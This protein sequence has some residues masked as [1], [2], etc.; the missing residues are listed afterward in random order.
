VESKKSTWDATQDGLEPSEQSGKLRTILETANEG[1]WEIDNENRVVEVNHKLCEILGLSR[2]ELLNRDST[3][4]IHKDS[5]TKFFEQIERRNRGLSSSYELTYV[6]PDGSL[7]HCMLNATPLFDD[8]GR[9]YGSF[10]LVTDITSKREA[11]LESQNRQELLESIFSAAPTGIGMVRNRII[12]EANDRLCEMIGYSKEEIVNQNSRFMYPSDEHYE[13]VGQ[14]KYRQIGQHGTGTVET[15]F[16]TKQGELI[17]VILSSTPLDLQDLDKGVTFTALDITDRKRVEQALIESQTTFRA[18][19]E[20]APDPITIMDLESFRLLEVNQRMSDHTGYSKQ[21]LLEMTPFDLDPA[22]PDA[23]KALAASAN[24]EHEIVFETQTRR[25][26]GS[27]VPVEIKSSIVEYGGK[28]SALNIGRDLSD[29]LRAEKEKKLLEEQLLQSQKMEAIGR[30][31]GGVAHDFNNILTIIL[32]TIELLQHTLEP[33]LR[34]NSILA[35]GIDQIEQSSQRATNLTRQ[36]LAFSRK[37]VFK[38][39]TLDLCLVISKMEGMLTRLVPENI[40]LK[41]EFDAEPCYIQGDTAQLEQIVLNLVVNSV[42]AMPDGGTLTLEVHKERT[43]GIQTKKL[44]NEYVRFSVIDSGIGMDA[45]LVEHI[46]EPFY[47]TKPTGEGTGLGLSTVHGIVKQMNGKISVQSR[48]NSGTRFSLT[49]PSTT[50]DASSPLEQ[51]EG[52]LYLRGTETVL[53]CEDDECVRLLTA[54][55]LRS[56]GYRVYEASNGK[57]ALKLVEELHCKLDMLITDVIMPEMNGKELALNLKERYPHLKVLFVSGYTADIIK[58]NEQVFQDTEL[59][60]KPYTA[61]TL[62]SHVRSILDR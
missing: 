38:P 53:I 59:I 46:F 16:L 48:I 39:E 12:V 44:E 36:L 4:F 2:Q 31:A 52:I 33:E 57:D 32:G 62:I 3:T 23:I 17:D 55:G 60:E 13:Y 15:Q 5:L 26:D 19:F 43:L 45:E 10:A 37:Q 8:L 9:K 27:L 42:D 56:H 47:T 30:L 34:E 22:D 50:L 29:R 28:K 18:L 20:N 54:Q 41:M 35:N 14:E 51:D 7:V 25:K 11:E 40:T 24:L 49:F 61:S 1:Y 6:K 58:P 21:E